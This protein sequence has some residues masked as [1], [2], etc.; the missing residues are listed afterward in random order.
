[1]YENNTT[2]EEDFEVSNLPVSFEMDKY[3]DDQ[4]ERVNFEVFQE[5]IH[6][7]QT[8]GFSR[9]SSLENKLILRDEYAGFV[10]GLAHWKSF[11]TL[12]FRDPVGG[13]VAMS[14]FYQLIQ[15]LNRR[16]YGKQYTRFVH[17]CYFSY[18]LGIEYQ[19][20][21]VIHFHVLVDKPIDFQL[22]HSWWNA[23]AGFAWI[24]PPDDLAAVVSYV[25]K[26]VVK[27]GDLFL[28]KSKTDRLPIPR[29]IWFT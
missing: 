4:Y 20:R 8:H 28:Y 17:H 23:V 27:D 19:R 16:L 11:V 7:N 26:Y 5:R 21:D 22:I 6:A 25:T 9:N 1:M 14:K 3:I 12:T 29:P 18:C 15:L 24:T 13:D 2:V 10:M